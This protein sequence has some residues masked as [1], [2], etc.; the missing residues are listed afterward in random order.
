[1]LESERRVQAPH[2]MRRHRWNTGGDADPVDAVDPPAARGNTRWEMDRERA[3]ALYDEGR[4]AMER[5]DLYTAVAKLR[6]SV[7]ILP[8]APSVA[9][10]GESLLGVS[11]YG[12]AVVHLTAALGMGA[13]WARLRTQLARALGKIGERREAIGLLKTALREQ[14][15][16]AEPR[17]ELQ[18]LLSDP[19]VIARTA[20]R[21]RLLQEL[22][23]AV[24]AIRFE[25]TDPPIKV[26]RSIGIYVALFLEMGRDHEELIPVFQFLNRLAVS[27][28]QEI[29]DLLAGVVFPVLAEWPDT[30]EVARRMLVGKGRSGFEDALALW[31]NPAPGEPVLTASTL[32]DAFRFFVPGF[33]LE[34][35]WPLEEAAIAFG[36]Y[37]ADRI[38]SG[39]ADEQLADAFTLLSKMGTLGD[40]RL[41]GGSDRVYEAFE[42]ALAE[43][44]DSRQPRIRQTALRLLTGKARSILE[45]VV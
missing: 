5:S 45:R 9:A 4:A 15:E 10:L 40:P 18:R 16:D 33:E 31:G 24:P 22:R 41:H 11:R 25:P 20:N 37:L 13:G 36:R 12:E 42:Q 34:L 38:M 35:A 32:L 23:I 29:A 6:E 2:R 14:P 44:L 39:V 19:E 28:D 3:L 8:T 43:L 27:P 7:A 17:T 26:L 21:H 1:M 30:T